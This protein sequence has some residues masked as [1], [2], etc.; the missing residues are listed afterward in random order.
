MNC[1]RFRLFAIKRPFSEL[2]KKD[3]EA[4]KNYLLKRMDDSGNTYIIDKFDQK[5]KALQS[6]S[7]LTRYQHKQWYWIEEE[8]NNAVIAKH[9]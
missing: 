6:M 4:N 7:E 8:V 5:D 1:G 3:L 2:L 9:F